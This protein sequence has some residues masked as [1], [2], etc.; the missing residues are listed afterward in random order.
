MDSILFRIKKKEDG[1]IGYSKNYEGTFKGRN[2]QEI[3]KLMREEFGKGHC[4]V[5][6]RKLIYTKTN[7]TKK[8][9]N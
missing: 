1:Y 6:R 4:Y 2:K 7:V 9:V 8:T 3:I 5:R